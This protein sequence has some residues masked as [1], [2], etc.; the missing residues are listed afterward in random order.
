M[1]ANVESNH[2]TVNIPEFTLYA[3]EN[4]TKVLE[5]PV[6]V[7]KEGTN[8][9]MFNGKLDQIVFSP[10]WNIPASI[11]KNEIMP[12]LIADPNYLKTKRWKL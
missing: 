2:I 3:Y 8:T 4:N 9:T 1:A 5:M 11:V 7:G 10:Y 6:V 12:K